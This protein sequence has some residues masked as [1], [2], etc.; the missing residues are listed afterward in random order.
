[1]DYLRAIAGF[2][3]L[4]CLAAAPKD[5][6]PEMSYL[7]NGTIKLGVDLKLGGAVTYLSPSKKELNLINSWD[8]GRQ[9]QM[10]YYSGPVPFKPGGKEPAPE[11]VG[12][13]WNPI[14]AGDHFGHGSK[15]RE[16]ANDGKTLYVKC[17]P[18]QWP[19]NDEPG[20]CTFE[21]WY[22]LEGS[23]VRVRC[24]L[25][26][27][28][29]DKTQYR[30]RGQ[31]L[32]A[33]YTNGPWHRLI[34]YKGDRPFSGDELSPVKHSLGQGGQPWAHWLATENWAALVDDNEWGIGVWNP[35][36]YGISG[37]FAGKPGAGGAKDGPTGY[38]GPSRQEIL[39]WNIEH[40]YSYALVVGS[41]KEIR[42]WVY[43]QPRRAAAPDY[44]FEKDRQGWWYVN[45]SDAGW[46][47][48]GEVELRL[49]GEDPQ[50][51]GPAGFWR[52]EDAPVLYVRAAFK[53]KQATAQVFWRTW[54]SGPMS[55]PV[56]FA[57]VADGEYRTYAVRLADAPE[58]R[59]AITGLRFDPVGKGEKGEWVKV[60]SMGFSK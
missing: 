31:E 15:A 11:W 36:C 55:K 3:A 42:A 56:D 17:V 34:T 23:A 33:V 49:D 30:A 12:L 1:M 26:N 10:S 59:G 22:S 8:W 54:G 32:P 60:K 44:S 2:V 14:Q 51:I 43:A 46:P 4:L 20:E 6:V 7:D 24:R 16:H 45:A 39:D 50:M 35:T 41:L 25:N 40:E 28:R 38:M 5:H 19:L 18:M 9:V 58:Y 52:A 48:K 53:T 57:V 47:I 27:A 21:T 29:S 37:G 13:G